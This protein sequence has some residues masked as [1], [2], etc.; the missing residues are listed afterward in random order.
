MNLIW[1]YREKKKCEKGEK[2][3]LPNS[4]DVF[5]IVNQNCLVFQKSSL[6][7]VY[8]KY[9]YQISHSKIRQSQQ[10]LTDNYRSVVHLYTSY[11]FILNHIYLQFKI[12][13]IIFIFVKK[14]EQIF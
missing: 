7:S 4:A 13:S 1:F 12:I 14:I 8:V 5:S 2:L 11:F 3:D 10:S 9:G 6:C